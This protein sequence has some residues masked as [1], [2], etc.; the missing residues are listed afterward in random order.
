MAAAGNLVDWCVTSECFDAAF[1]VAASEIKLGGMTAP[2]VVIGDFSVLRFL[3]SVVVAGVVSNVAMRIADTIA[4]LLFTHFD[5]AKC[6]LPSV[7][8][9]PDPPGNSAP[10]DVPVPEASAEQLGKFLAFRGVAL[11]ATEAARREA[12]AREAVSYMA[13]LFDRKHNEWCYRHY[14][15][16]EKGLCFPYR[17]PFMN[18]WDFYG[19][20]SAHLRPVGNG[21]VIF[22]L[23]HTVEGLLLPLL[24]FSSGDAS[25]FYLALYADMG[26]EAYDILAL[27]WRRATGADH[28]LT[29]H[30]PSVDAVLVPH[31]LFAI[32]YELIGLMAGPLLSKTFMLHVVASAHLSGVFILAAIVLHQTPAQAWPRFLYG[33]QGAVLA[34]IYACRV[35]WWAPIAAASLRLAYTGFLPPLL[36]PH[37]VASEPRLL[38]PCFA[39]MLLLIAFY[40]Y[41][42]ADQIV[43]NRK[44]LR[45]AGERLRLATKK[46]RP[47]YSC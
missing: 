35:V 14:A 1:R 36:T 17:A 5:A 41:F 22:A 23:H 42:N 20:T 39:A 16:K 25:F 37:G 24:Y 34:A 45:K 15:L 8:P 19:E 38:S 7:L 21:Q 6:S 13:E 11:P 2:D 44:L 40:T 4:R 27:L 30:H 31:H 46:E 12:A 43:Y 3:L 33:F 18:A 9:W 28:T 26:V 47:S 10:F 32:C 29:R